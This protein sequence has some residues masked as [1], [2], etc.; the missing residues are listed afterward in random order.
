MGETEGKIHFV[1]PGD[2]HHGGGERTKK[3]LYAS[4]APYPAY[5]YRDWSVGCDWDGSGCASWEITEPSN[6]YQA[7]FVLLAS[8]MMTG[9]I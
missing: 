3:V 8:F 5:A 2:G 7:A 4:Y 6:G 9:A 1:H